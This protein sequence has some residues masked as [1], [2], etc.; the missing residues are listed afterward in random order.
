MFIL[1]TGKEGLS[2]LGVDHAR[3][4]HR[5]PRDTCSGA[6]RNCVRLLDRS[7]QD[8]ALDWDGGADRATLM[9]ALAMSDWLPHRADPIN[10]I[11]DDDLDWT[12]SWRIGRPD[13]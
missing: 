8:P 13:K 12:S 11:L 2:T 3:G 4:P 5:P 1:D 6:A 7:G 9:A 10:G